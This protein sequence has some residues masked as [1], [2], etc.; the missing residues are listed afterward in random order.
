MEVEGERVEGRFDQVEGGVLL[1]EA[2][3]LLV[4]ALIESLNAVR[5][6]KL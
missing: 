1:V 5:V 4:G 3:G 6:S 2:V